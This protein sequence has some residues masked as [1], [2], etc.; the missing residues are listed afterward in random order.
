MCL[1]LPSPYRQGREDVGLSTP[2][3]KRH[4]SDV[5]TPVDIA[6]Q[7]GDKKSQP[8]DA[9]FGIVFSCRNVTKASRAKEYRSRAAFLRPSRAGRIPRLNDC[10]KSSGPH[11]RRTHNKLRR[12]DAWPFE[13]TI[14][15]H[16]LG[17]GDTKSVSVCA[18]S[19]Y[20]LMI[21]AGEKEREKKKR[22]TPGMPVQKPVVQKSAR[23]ILRTL[24]PL[25]RY[26]VGKERS[27]ILYMAPLR[28]YSVHV[29]GVRVVSCSSSFFILFFLLLF[30]FPV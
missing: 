2:L 13:T 22:R 23:K 3:P 24:P 9:Y 10:R 8:L 29:Y 6:R 11:F 19:R 1:S 7:I 25:I 15:S 27:A 26:R 12:G 4:S 17:L 18:I 28:E 21:R 14:H 16:E 20:G 30:F 5:G